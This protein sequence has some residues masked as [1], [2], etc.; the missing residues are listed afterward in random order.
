MNGKVEVV[1]SAAQ[2]FTDMMDTARST[3]LE[4]LIVVLILAELIIAGIALIK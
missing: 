1:A 2:T 4:I 3:R